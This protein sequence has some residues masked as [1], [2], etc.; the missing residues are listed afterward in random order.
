[1]T[2]SGAIV[3]PAWMTEPATR[4]V[5]AALQAGGQAA[6]FVGGAVRDAVLGRPVTDIDIATPLAPDAAMRALEAAGIKVVPTGIDHGT[7]TAVIER[8]HLEITTLRRDVETDGRH[9]RVAYTDDWA[10]DAARRDFTINAL[11]AD[12]DGTLYD[13][14]GQGLDD[15]NAGRVRFIGDPTQRI[16]EDYLRLLRF[17]RFQARYG[18]G[19][20]DA[21][22]VAACA[23]AAAQLDRL[24]AE[25]VWAE[26]KRLLAAVDPAPM[27]ALMAAQR[28]LPHVLPRPADVGC[29]ERLVAGERDVPIVPLCRLAALVGRL[30]AVEP[31]AQRLRLSNAESARLA[32]ILGA[33]A[34]VDQPP[35]RL[36]RRF[37]RDA[38]LDGVRLAAARGL[39][40]AAAATARA[41]ITAWV[42]LPLP[43]TGDD[44]LSL[45]V[46]PG[47]LV[48]EL[49]GQ[50]AA[51][52]EE[53][54]CGADRKAC[55]AALR[56]LARKSRW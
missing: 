56:R 15:L 12:A 6:R 35:C 16:A 28:I 7:V 37:G 47:R 10:A 55:L 32:G 20:P 50:V 54:D 1:M 45:G 29:L 53:Q 21:A 40:P 19:A 17:F 49:L 34:I 5:I 14:T 42:E 22:A 30:D 25:R 36:V 41:K 33:A 52:W 26:L 31:T 2:P 18:S 4:R 23:A 3:P 46:P 48:G 8:R 13:P 9:A 51:W 39:G 43:I 24:S 11:F 44:V 27:I 38:A